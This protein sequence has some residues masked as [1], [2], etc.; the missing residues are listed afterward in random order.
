M[1]WTRARCT[2]LEHERK[3]TPCH[4]LGCRVT[5]TSWLKSES[6]H[7]SSMYMC[8]YPWV[9]FSS[10]IRS[11]LHRPLRFFPL[12][13][14]ELHTELDNL[15][16][17]Q[18]LSNDAYD[19]SVSLTQWDMFPELTQLHLIGC[20]SE[21]IWTQK[22]KNQLADIPTK[23]NFARDEWNHLLCLFDISQFSSTVCSD[24]MA[25]RSQQ[26][27]GEERVTAKSRF[28]MNL[29]ARTPSFVLSVSSV[30]K[31]YGSQDPWNSVVGEDGSGKL[32]KQIYL[33]LLI[34]TTMSNS[35]RA[36]S[37]DYSKLDYD[38]AW[39]SQEWKA[40]ATTHD[41]SGWLDQT[42]WRM[43]RKVR[44]DHE[45]I[46]LEEPRNPSGT[47]KHFVID[48]GDLV[49][50]ILKKRQDLK[51]SSWND[52]TELELSVEWRSFVNW[53][54]DQVWKWQERISNVTGDGEEHSTIWR[55]L[56]AVTMKSAVFMGKNFQNN[57]KSIVNTA[58]LTLTQMFNIS[59]KLVS[60]QDEISSLETIGWETPWE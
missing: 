33:N 25:K 23:G 55:M 37:K 42:S 4:T 6:H 16:I 48:E 46:L 13:H 34:I 24:T 36:S 29:I 5:C 56:M 43:V 8:V 47:E 41:R 60:E 52:E 45:G 39:S 27:S 51:I 7:V 31:Y 26:D 12:L 19:V 50:S 21:S 15:I 2:S 54:N 3:R 30:K 11:V 22:S 57:Q 20:L 1:T 32:G 35:W 40:E 38:R 14:I 9:H 17:M 18:N 28:L 58:D 53:V 59:A 49:I 44:L 10:S